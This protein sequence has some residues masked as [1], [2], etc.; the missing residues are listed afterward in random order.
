MYQTM[1]SVLLDTITVR[2]EAFAGLSSGDVFFTH[3]ELEWTNPSTSDAEFRVVSEDA[4][5]L[6]SSSTT[7]S[8]GQKTTRNV[9]PLEPGTS[10]KLYLERLEFGEWIRQTSTSEMDYAL[11]STP[12]T[13][14]SVTSGSTTAKVTFQAPVADATYSITYG[15]NPLE[16]DSSAP[17][18]IS[19]TT[20]EA[21]MSGLSQGQAY[22][23]QMY[24]MYPDNIVQEFGPSE[25]GVVLSQTSFTTSNN[26]EMVVTGPYASYMLLD[27]SESVDGTGSNYRIVHREQG[28]EDYVLATSSTTT[29]ATIQDLRPGTEYNIVLQRL[30]VNGTWSDQNEVVVNTLTSALSMSSVASTTLEVSWNL[31]YPGANFE[32]LYSKSG[33]EASTSGQTQETSVILRN[34][35]SATD[36]EISLLVYELG[37]ASLLSTL[38]MTTKSRRGMSSNTKLGI[39]LVVV[40]I[41]VAVLLRKKK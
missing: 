38:G 14:M 21:I 36:Y 5:P 7:L 33:G 2:T 8:G 22:T 10:N 16:L 24:V 39:L 6:T 18:S 29:N 40:G 26:A 12:T 27:W 4:A 20:G 31:L 11:V 34:L 35:E 3:A 25:S 9:F 30:E 41:L 23:V 32:V 15:T 28:V 13:S 19:G 37:Q 17:V 1:S